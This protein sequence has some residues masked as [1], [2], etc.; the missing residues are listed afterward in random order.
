MPHRSVC[1]EAWEGF[2]LRRNARMGG[3]SS[4][5]R[6]TIITITEDRD[7]ASL[8]RKTDLLK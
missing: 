6:I 4:V 2:R 8:L 5:V 3:V 7:I 1:V